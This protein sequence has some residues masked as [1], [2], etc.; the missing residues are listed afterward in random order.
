[1]SNQESLE[2]DFNR[3][4]AAVD[5]DP[6][7]NVFMAYSDL[8]I[9]LKNRLYRLPLQDKLAV[10]FRDEG[11]AFV[12]NVG[13]A[14]REDLE[15]HKFDPS[16][17]ATRDQIEWT[18]V[19]E[20]AALAEAEKALAT[21]AAI[22]TL[23]P[24]NPPPGK[25][26]FTVV[27]LTAFDHKTAVHLFQ[28]STSAREITRRGIVIS[29]FDN[30][31]ADVVE[32]TFLFDDAWPVIVNGGHAYSLRRTA[33]ER[34]FDLGR[35]VL[36][37]K[38][39]ITKAIIDVIPLDDAAPFL[40]YCATRLRVLQKLEMVARR[41]YFSELTIDKIARAIASA[42]LAIELE[43]E[44]DKRRLVCSRKS[45]SDIVKLLNDDFLVSLG[46]SDQAYRVTAKRPLSR[47]RQ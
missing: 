31:F 33:F 47:S 36:E 18:P 6:G 2:P 14:L 22:E 21:P 13:K 23:N 4:E 32:K 19:A 45:V 27:T 24:D 15:L 20:V 5:G 1:M 44:G 30:A 9:G 16:T 42:Q 26:V 41:P 11:V 43:G 40:A 35:A 39:A 46:I 25:P 10:R 3:V 37:R 28:P 7:V 12:R 17:E 38:D 34:M 8:K 29:W